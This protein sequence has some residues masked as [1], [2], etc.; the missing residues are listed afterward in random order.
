MDFNAGFR[1][2]ETYA[3]GDNRVV[4]VLTIDGAATNALSGGN[5][6]AMF[7]LNGQPVTVQFN[8]N[9]V[10]ATLTI[11]NAT[12]ITLAAGVDKLPE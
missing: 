3:G 6:G 8:P 9:A 10:G 1:F 11:G 5:D 4:H 2:D 12:P 7:N